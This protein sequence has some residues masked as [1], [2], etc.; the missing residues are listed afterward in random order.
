MA[1]AERADHGQ[2][3]NQDA[4]SDENEMCHSRLRIVRANMIQ[5]RWI[6]FVALSSCKGMICSENRCPLFGI[7]P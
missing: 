1:E 7:M 2:H 3:G 4:E 6:M 5:L